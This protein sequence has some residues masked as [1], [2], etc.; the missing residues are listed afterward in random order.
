M[1]IPRLSIKTDAH[2]GGCC[3]F[4]CLIGL[5]HYIE[6]LGHALAPRVLQM[7]SASAL[8]TLKKSAVVDINKGNL[9]KAVEKLQKLVRI[10]ESKKSGGDSL[11]TVPLW[12]LLSEAYKQKCNFPSAARVNQTILTIVP[13]SA[14]ARFQVRSL[15]VYWIIETCTLTAD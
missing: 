3:M 8:F 14:S 12:S 15:I 4:T 1:C 7:A 5:C 10:A 11:A 13:D 9:D 2:F 6:H